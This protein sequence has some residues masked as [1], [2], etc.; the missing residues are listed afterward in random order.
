MCV[1]AQFFLQK[2]KMGTFD[3]TVCLVLPF[4]SESQELTGQYKPISKLRKFVE[5]KYFMK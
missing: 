3:D 2:M 5:S 1:F 4:V